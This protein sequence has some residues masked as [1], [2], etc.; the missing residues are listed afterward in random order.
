MLHR[1]A[2]NHQVVEADLELDPASQL[3]ELKG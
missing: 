2:W 3:L 1:L